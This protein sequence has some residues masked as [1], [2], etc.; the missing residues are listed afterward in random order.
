MSICSTAIG[1]HE[2]V[3]N[4]WVYPIA[5]FNVA[6]VLMLDGLCLCDDPSENNRAWLSLSMNFARAMIYICIKHVGC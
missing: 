1:T 3:Q 2:N 6:I 5:T 4:G